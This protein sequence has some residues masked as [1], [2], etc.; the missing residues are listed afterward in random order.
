MVHQRGQ[1]R[2]PC[3]KEA[4]D[5][6]KKR[7]KFGYFASLEQ[8]SPSDAL[9]QTVE[10]EQAGADSIWV[11]DHFQPWCHAHAHAAHAWVWM[12]TALQATRQ[13]FFSTAVTCPIFRYHP[14]IV[15]QAFAT[16][17]R[18]FPGRVGLGIGAG[19]AI[20]EFPI[21]E[22]WPPV[23]VRQ[24]MTVEAVRL[25]RELWTREGQVA[26]E[27]EHFRFRGASLYTKPIRPIPLYFS[28]IG[29]R[30]ACL[31]GRFGDH[32]ITAA[33]PPSAIAQSVIPNFEK[34]AREAGRDPSSM[35]RVLLAWYSIDPDYGRAAEGLRFWAG[36][37]LPAMLKYPVA[38]PQEVQ[39]H[40]GYV[41]HEAIGKTFFPVTDA[42]G[43]IRRVEEYHAA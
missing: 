8:Y 28:G 21:T 17:D 32:L 38:D 36:A 14:A 23:K 42:E 6:V 4:E 2:T 20:N 31:A 10:A 16:L 26:F 12:A 3:V 22:R 29:P 15:A 40:A 35:E 43:L 34:G 30:G 1:R 7:I 11:D 25:I 13:V 41:S 24:D 27:G 5:M 37:M 39:A 33:Q 19:E 9:M 18:L